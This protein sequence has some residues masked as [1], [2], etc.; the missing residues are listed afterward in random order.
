MRDHD[1]RRAIWRNSVAASISDVFKLR[2]AVEFM[3]IGTLPN[4][5]KAIEDARDYTS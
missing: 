5:G 3:P 2:G 1:D 4:D